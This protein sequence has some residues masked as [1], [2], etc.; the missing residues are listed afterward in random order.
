MKRHDTDRPLSPFSENALRPL[1]E[2]LSAWLQ[3]VKQNFICAH[4]GDHEL[5]CMSKRYVRKRFNYRSGMYDK[6][7]WFDV[8]ALKRCA[9]CKKIISGSVIKLNHLKR[10]TAAVEIQRFV[11]KGYRPLFDMRDN[12]V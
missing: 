5:V 6:N 7:T 8:T 9:A 12:P 1:R 3:L 10:K 4:E 11:G 2:A